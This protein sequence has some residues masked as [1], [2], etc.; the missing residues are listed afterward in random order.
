MLILFW[1]MLTFYWEILTDCLRKGKVKV[2]PRTQH[3]VV[4]HRVLDITK[5][6]SVIF[7]TND[8]NIT[9]TKQDSILKSRDIALPTNS[10]LV[11]AM[12][13]PIVLYGCKSW[14][15]KRLRAEELML[16]NCGV[17]KDS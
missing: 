2:P 5:R 7:E 3:I 4:F 16:S 11:K 15:I 13:F 1:K 8:Q 17:G 14:T 12:V 6:L 9:M 10:H